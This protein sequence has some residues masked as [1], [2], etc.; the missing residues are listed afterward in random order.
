MVKFHN[1][2][3]I[4]PDYTM[5]ELRKDNLELNIVASRVIALCS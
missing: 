3:A 1:L 5:L 4:I 2:G